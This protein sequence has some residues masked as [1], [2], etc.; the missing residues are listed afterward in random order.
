MDWEPFAT[1]VHAYWAPSG[2]LVLVI[3]STSC[4]VQVARVVTQAKRRTRTHPT[5]SETP[6]ADCSQETDWPR[7]TVS[8]STQGHQRSDRCCCLLER[9]ATRFRVV[10]KKTCSGTSMPTA[11]YA[12]RARS[13]CHLQVVREG[14]SFGHIMTTP[15]LDTSVTRGLWNSSGAST[16]GLAW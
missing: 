15:W 6:C 4:H 13:T 14:Q 3:V 7:S 11:Y 1:R 2:S 10:R 16:T 12:T 5:I 9:S 8:G